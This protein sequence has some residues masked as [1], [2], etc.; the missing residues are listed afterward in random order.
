MD[1]TKVLTHGRRLDHPGVAR[2][3]GV[4]FCRSC[5]AAIVGV[6]AAAI[7]AS[8]ADGRPPGPMVAAA[9]A[10][11]LS[12]VH[13]LLPLFVRTASRGL[14]AA[15]VVWWALGCVETR[16]TNMDVFL[17]VLSVGLVVSRVVR[18]S[19]RKEYVAT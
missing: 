13:R 5:A 6:C 10:V 9:L 12:S 14:S 15:T 7:A 2:L 1:A 4:S 16:W 8:A 19:R 17:A 11:S 3:G 18:G